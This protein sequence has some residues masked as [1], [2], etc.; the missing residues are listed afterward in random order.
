MDIV[1][2]QDGV[3]EVTVELL[4]ELLNSAGMAHGGLIA[5]LVD[6]A[7]GA[8]AFSIVAEDKMAV[9]TDFNLTCLKSSYEG[10]LKAT[11]KV[12]HRGRRL[13]RSD[14]EVYSDQTLIAKAGVSFMVIDRPVPKA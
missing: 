13:I 1:S 9:T 7:A 2:M 4:P 8:A 6:G 5:T 10:L 11:G 14:V 12:I 3:A